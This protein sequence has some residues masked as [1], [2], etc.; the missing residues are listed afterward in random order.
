MVPRVQY[1]PGNAVGLHKIEPQT[2]SGS[3]KAKALSFRNLE[4]LLLVLQCFWTLSPTSCID[5]LWA[6][7]SSTKLSFQP[8]TN[9]CIKV[10][11]CASGDEWFF[12]VQNGQTWEEAKLTKHKVLTCFVQEDKDLRTSLAKKNQIFFLLEVL[13]QF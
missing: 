9:S 13:F 11:A 3:G 5:P 6:Y 7:P 10:R 2:L 1:L 12:S 4:I 8:L